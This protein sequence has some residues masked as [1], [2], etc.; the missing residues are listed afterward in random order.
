MHKRAR[1]LAVLLATFA[2]GVAP[3]PTAAQGTGGS[4]LVDRVAAVVGDSTVLLSQVQEEIERLLLSDPNLPRR[5]TPEYQEFFTEILGTWVDRMLVLQAAEQ[6]SLIQ[7]DEAA[8]DRQIAERLEALA[9]QFG[10]QPA[11]QQALAR[12]GWTLAEYRENL[13]QD[14]RQVQTFQM[15]FQ[16]RLRD[17]RPVEVSEQELLQRFQEASAQLQQR[18]RT[19]TFRQVVVRPEASDSAKARARAEAEALLDRVLAGEDFA[20]LA[21]EHSDDVGTAPLGGD[22]GWFRRGQMVPEFE[23]AAFSIAPGRVSTV[24]ETV[25]GYH[26]IK[27]ERVR[28]RSEVQARHILI[29]PESGPADLD[30]A[31][32]LGQQIAERARAGESM[33]ELFDEFSD[34]LVPDSLTV[35]FD[36]LDEFPAA[37][38]ALRLASKGDVMGPL[39]YQPGGTQP[40]DLRFAVVKVL[41]VR[42]AGAYTFEDLRPQIASQLQQEKQRQLILDELRSKTYV[43]IR[44]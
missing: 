24:I 16:L 36:Q 38:S 42:E 11:L 27:V 37:Y 15:F 1:R 30:T 17:A 35:A 19:M 8:I 5:G 22:L 34:P 4:E 14:A 18:P 40:G 9:G 21:T 6:D 31:R 26:I 29:V 7:P 3:S 20:A 28:G 10:G 32:Q 2:V 41:E 12:E 23:N 43:D 44:M 13:R 25:F 39:E 33:Q